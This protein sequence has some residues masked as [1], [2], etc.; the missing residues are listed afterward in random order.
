MRRRT[1]IR[2]LGG[3][4]AF[5]PMLVHAQPVPRPARVGVLVLN[6][7]DGRSIV[8]LL[9]EGLHEAGYVEG[10][11]L[12]FEVRSADG[13]VGQLADLAAELV[14]LNV[15]LIVAV[16]TPCAL[17]A[18]QATARIPIVAAAVA[19]PIGTGLAASLAKPGGNVTG[20]TNLAAETAGKTVELLHDMIP[21]LRRVAA[22]ANPADAFTRPFVE[23]VQLAGRTTKIEIKPIALARGPEDFEAA[24]AA[25]TNEHAEA[26]VVQGILFPKLIADLAIKH[27]LPTA[28][29]VRAYSDQGGLMTYGPSIT[30]LFR[31]SSVFVQKIL[32]GASPMDLPIEQ[33]TKFELVINLR[34]AKAIGL[35]IPE[36]F[37]LR[38]DT[39]IE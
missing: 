10:Q 26:V 22:L 13:K 29:V 3:A 14:R 27:R 32:Q 33:A 1:F 4:A 2:C 24:F 6:E 8:G 12:R 28:S 31:R 5:G 17:A 25:I 7:T 11:N 23:Q 37:L 15:D 39:V 9:R 35:T 21:T 19:D 38:A 30:D 36:S 16:F 18:K 20:L 34:T